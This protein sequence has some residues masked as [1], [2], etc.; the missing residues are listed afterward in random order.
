MS[1]GSSN[2]LE[3]EFVGNS[4]TLR[5]TDHMC[6]L[7]VHWHIKTNYMDHWRVKLTVT[8]LNYNRNYTNWNLVVHHPGFSQSTTTYSFNNTLLHTPGIP[9]K[10]TTFFHIVFQML[11]SYMISI[12]LFKI[13][14]S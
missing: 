7:R 8:N 13:I 11:I 3:T 14:R 5:C 6:P 12:V 9:G 1:S 4:D 10:L 2:S